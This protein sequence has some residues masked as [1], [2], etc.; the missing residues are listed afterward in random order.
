M[1]NKTPFDPKLEKALGNLKEQSFEPFFHTR[2][3]GKLAPSSSIKAPV[4]KWL[5]SAYAVSAICIFGLFLFSEQEA[6]V[7]HF[8]G[9]GDYEVETELEM[10]SFDQIT[11]I[12]ND[13]Y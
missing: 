4:F 2:V 6:T 12:N 5:M 3:M 10:T 7:D 1:E 9:I 11:L 8:L 13:E